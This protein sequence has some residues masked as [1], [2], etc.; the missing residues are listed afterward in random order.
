MPRKTGETLVFLVVKLRACVA[1]LNRQNHDTHNC[2]TF[3]MSDE[4]KTLV[5]DNGSFMIRAGFA[6]DDAPKSVFQ[7]VVGH[8]KYA[9]ALPSVPGEPDKPDLYVGDEAS[10]ETGLFI[11]Q[12]PI[13]RGT[14]TNWDDMKRIW[15]YIFSHKLHVDPM[16]HPVLFNEHW[17]VSKHQREELIRTMFEV[18]SVPSFYVAQST[19]LA[20]WATGRTTACVVNCG[21]G[22]TE[23]ACYEDSR[24]Q[25]CGNYMHFGGCDI[26]DYMI[27]LFRHLGG[28]LDTWSDREMV[29]KAKEQWGYVAL[30]FNEEMKK[31]DWDRD[32]KIDYTLPTG[33]ALYIT[34]ERFRCP[35]LLF[36][37]GLNHFP[38]DSI[39]QALFDSI[40]KCDIY[41][42][43][44]MYTNIVLSGGTTMFQ[45]LPER[46][47][48][49]IDRL[50]PPEMRVKIVA[51]PERE[52]AVWKGGSMLASLSTFPQMVITHEEYNEVGP[53]V[54][55]RKCPHS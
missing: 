18:H 8:P 19:A 45:G 14:I 39:T 33:N 53:N 34:D 12:Y 1:S 28:R 3:A 46:V 35:E 27:K 25:K 5:I 38:C 20:L 23:I 41:V 50:A 10:A 13:Q 40:S 42:R 32:C 26:T 52:N 36:Q 6:D 21:D 48:K 11:A 2:F 43:K 55:H 15:H 4:V 44:D 9:L 24:V 51:P 49:E 30:D 16:E 54:V 22:L 31:K 7:S 29:R 47:E 37:P 17:N